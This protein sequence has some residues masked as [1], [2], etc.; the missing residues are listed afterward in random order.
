MHIYIFKVRNIKYR[1]YEKR[2]SANQHAYQHYSID[3]D[4]PTIMF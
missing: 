2:L 1:L 4:I 3:V